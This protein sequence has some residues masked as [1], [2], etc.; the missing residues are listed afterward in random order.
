VGKQIKAAMAARQ[1]NRN[2]AAGAY[3]AGAGGTVDVGG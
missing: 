3:D 2:Y 1:V